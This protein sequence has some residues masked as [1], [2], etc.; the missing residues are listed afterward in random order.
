MIDA[1]TGWVPGRDPEGRGKKQNSIKDYETIGESMRK[2]RKFSSKVVVAAL[3][4]AATGWLDARAQDAPVAGANQPQPRPATTT[5]SEQPLKV[6]K[7][8]QL[9]G[10]TVENQ[11]GDKLGKIDDVVVDFDNARVSYC[12]LSVEHKIFATPKY[13]AVPLAAMRPSAD[14]SRLILNADKDKVAQAQGF[15]RNNWPSVSS[16]AWG[17]QPFWQTDSKGAITTP[18]DQNKNNPSGTSR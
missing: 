7:C 10:I 5:A 4:L 14:G 3:C 12:V 18:S 6:N 9:I 15:D 17:A 16:P 2:T 8:S 11:Q 13:L 1:E